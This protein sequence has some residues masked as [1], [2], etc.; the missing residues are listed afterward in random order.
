MCRYLV[1]YICVPYGHRFPVKR[2]QVRLAGLFAL[3]T[4]RKY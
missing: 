4:R 2:M 1:Y 3:S